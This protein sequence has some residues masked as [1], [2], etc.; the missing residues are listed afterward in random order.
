M[1]K[2]SEDERMALDL[3]DAYL[4]LLLAQTWQHAQNDAL[5][6]LV[7][8]HAEVVERVGAAAT[9]FDSERERGVAVIKIVGALQRAQARPGPDPLAYVGHG[10]TR[11]PAAGDLSRRSEAQDLRLCREVMGI[12]EW[13]RMRAA[14]GIRGEAL[15]WEIAAA[16]GAISGALGVPLFIPA[17]RDMVMHHVRR[18]NQD[19]DARLPRHIRDYQ[20]A[21]PRIYASD[22]KRLAR[23]AII[24]ELRWLA[25]DINLHIGASFGWDNL[26]GFDR[27]TSLK[28]V[29]TY[30]HLC[31]S[32]RVSD[33]SFKYRDAL[34]SRATQEVAQVLGPEMVRGLTLMMRAEDDATRRLRKNIVDTDRSVV[35]VDG[36]R[37]KGS[38]M[39]LIPHDDDEFDLEGQLGL[40]LMR[41]EA[42]RHRRDGPS[43]KL[44][45]YFE[46]FSPLLKQLGEKGVFRRK[47]IPDKKNLMF[48]LANLVCENIYRNARRRKILLPGGK[49]ARSLDDARELTVAVLADAGFRYSTDSL[50]D[51]RAEFK[52]DY[53]GR[54][55]AIFGLKDPQDGRP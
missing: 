9:V 34:S 21:L 12:V 5:E 20:D 41:M 45:R 2:N 38:L 33:A 1:A 49:R 32:G 30:A 18:Q 17:L 10:W 31:N 29:N 3:M 15:D 13:A 35:Y 40:L 16:I 24:A 52:R 14:S 47:I 19:A 53:L 6:R 28:A 4:Q 54:V 22:R 44:T 23:N 46:R 11:F 36:R 25:K 48:C 42:V 26:A 27:E 7:A 51:R 37:V 55:P 39:V 50:R 8:L 43:G